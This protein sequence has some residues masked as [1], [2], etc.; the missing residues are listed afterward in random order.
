[1]PSGAVRRRGGRGSPFVVD[2]DPTPQ[3][4][5]LG[6][7]RGAGTLPRRTS[8]L[9]LCRVPSSWLGAADVRSSAW[10]LA[11]DSQVDSQL[12]RAAHRCDPL[13]S[14]PSGQADCRRALCAELS[15]VVL[16]PAPRRPSASA[17]CGRSSAAI[18]H[19]GPGRR[20]DTRER[21]RPVRRSA[22]SRPLLATR[23]WS[24]RSL[25]SPPRPR[26]RSP[27]PAPAR[28]TRPL[29][30]SVDPA[31]PATPPWRHTSRMS[32]RRLSSLRLTARPRPDARHRRDPTSRR[33]TRRP[34]GDRAAS[35]VRPGAAPG[36]T[37]NSPARTRRGS[38]CRCPRLLHHEPPIRRS[39]SDG[40]G[41]SR[42]P[43]GCRCDDS[44]PAIAVAG[45]RS[46]P[47]GQARRAGPIG[48]RRGS[49]RGGECSHAPQVDDSPSM[50][51][52]RLRYCCGGRTPY[53]VHDCWRRP[54]R[55]HRA[56]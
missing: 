13:G 23:P 15:P 32:S 55:L 27:A 31:R 21:A 14:S 19:K 43:S 29:R 44:R 25:G 48:E 51:R 56:R 46:G 34:R 8:V 4:S 45:D 40:R 18:P 1:M 10:R 38:R 37:T 17:T 42:R 22:P 5:D 16:R 41:A 30:R 11:F 24:R 49:G 53:Q 26:P 50:N 35:R 3:R 20:G 36:R 47:Y 39:R 33:A 28:A 12:V 6:R 9:Q 54:S 52:R 2:L 7:R